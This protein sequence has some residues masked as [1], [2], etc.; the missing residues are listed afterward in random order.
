MNIVKDRITAG[1]L[2]HSDSGGRLCLRRLRGVIDSS[3]RLLFIF[4]WV[5]PHL[6]ALV[7]FPVVSDELDGWQNCMS[8]LT[9]MNRFEI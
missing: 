5:L 4:S 1:A 9:L 7:V 6:G 3:V 2:T 8:S